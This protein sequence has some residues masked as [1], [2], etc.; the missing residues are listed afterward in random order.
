MRGTTAGV[1]KVAAAFALA[2]EELLTVAVRGA[3]SAVEAA[4]GTGAIA[5]RLT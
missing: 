3:P 4:F 2:D 5:Y 1:L